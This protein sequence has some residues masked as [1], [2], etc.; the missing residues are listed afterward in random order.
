MGPAR[1]T[2]IGEAM[3]HPVRKKIDLDRIMG[4]DLE[5]RIML[6]YTADP[7]LVEAVPLTEDQCERLKQHWRWI[8]ANPQGIPARWT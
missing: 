4:F 1:E 6:V 2:E 3:E 5:R 8:A 7:G